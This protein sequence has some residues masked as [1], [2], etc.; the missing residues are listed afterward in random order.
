MTHRKIRTVVA[1]SMLVALMALSATPAFAGGKKGG[2]PYQDN[3]TASAV[4]GN[5]GNGGAA[6]AI[7]ICAIQI[8][9][10]GDAGCANNGVADGSG[11]DGGNAVAVADQN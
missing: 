4:G 1:S 3:D 6:V 11:G 9:V 5:G 2:G 10:I 8:A 7:G